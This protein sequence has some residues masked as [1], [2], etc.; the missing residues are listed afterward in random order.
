MTVRPNQTLTVLTHIIGWVIFF[1]SPI[2]I[3]PGP[4]VSAY[5]KQPDI[6]FSMTL[7][8]LLWMALFYFNLFFLTPY[9]LQRKGVATFLLCLV[10]IIIVFDSADR[11]LDHQWPDRQP[12]AFRQGH[13]DFRDHP[14]PGHHEEFRPHGRPFPFRG[15]GPMLSNLLLTLITTAA[16]SLIVLWKNWREVKANESEQALQKFTAELSILKLQI[17]PHFLFNTLNNIRWLIRSKSDQAETAVVKL[18]QL[19]RYILYQTNTEKVPL[20]KEV[21]HLK[22]FISLQ[23]LRLAEKSFSFTCD[24][25]LNGVYI[26][27]LLLIPVVENFFKYGNFHDA[28]LNSILLTLQDRKVTFKTQNKILKAAEVKELEDKG[29]GLENI[30]KRLQLHYPNKHILKISDNGDI[31]VLEMEI[32]LD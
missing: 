4:D 2:L 13:P 31:F 19:M 24:D 22:D 26:V 28:S 11:W 16:S 21:E 17:S 6:L 3:A 8:N 29:I 1:L 10:V 7:K 23:Q 9:I 30:R 25:N 20:E 15:G 14:P 27:P 32:I 18:S 12:E 5:F